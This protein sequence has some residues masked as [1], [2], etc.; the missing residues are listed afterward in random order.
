VLTT[1]GRVLW[2]FE[3]LLKVTYGRRQPAMSCVS[4][5][6]ALS[7][8]CAGDCSPMA[9]YSPYFYD[10]GQPR[11]ST[12]RLGARYTSTATDRSI[13]GA[14]P[15]LIKHR[16]VLCNP[17]GTT[18]LI[19]ARVAA[20]F[21]LGC[22]PFRRRPAFTLTRREAA[23]GHNGNDAPLGDR[24]SASTSVPVGLTAEGRLLWNYE[25]LLHRNF[26]QRRP[27]IPPIG[28]AEGVVSCTGL[29]N[30]P[31]RY[32]FSRTGASTM[33]V[34]P[35]GPRGVDFGNYPDPMLLHGKLIACSRA[36]QRMLVEYLD[37][38]SFTLGCLEPRLPRTVLQRTG[39]H[40]ATI[41]T[42]VFKVSDLWTLNLTFSCDSRN[43]GALTVQAWQTGRSG[44]IT[45]LT[46]HT[47]PAGERDHVFYH[48]GSFHLR[49]RLQ[50]NTRHCPWFVWAATR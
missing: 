37:A 15:V 22:I 24:S 31:Y 13:H 23:P 14:L 45:T 38:A 27:S 43:P 19:R 16:F 21:T 10:F 46:M 40:D 3:A 12:F 30:L 11:S 6:A 7:F 29:C 9:T 25:A 41:T 5:C 39:Q 35:R 20:T 34:T 33:Y 48:A 1:R 36:G 42:R 47:S 4:S 8:S 50:R 26:G 28:S 2:E 32:V 17:D 18:I 44:A 49:I